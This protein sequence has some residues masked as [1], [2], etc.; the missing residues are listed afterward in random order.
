MRKGES[1]TALE[2][3]QKAVAASKGENSTY[4]EHYVD[5]PDQGPGMLRR[6]KKDRRVHQNR[7]MPPTPSKV[8]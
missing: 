4:N 5:F 8:G 7:L 2:I 3:Q 6:Q 1:K